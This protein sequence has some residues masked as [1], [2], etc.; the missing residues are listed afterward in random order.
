ML[1]AL[2]VGGVADI[3]YHLGA[4]CL[5][6]RRLERLDEVMRQTAD[7]SD[8]VDEHDPPAV[9]QHQRA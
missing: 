8:G 5:L 7:K 2:G 3:Q 4:D 6:K 9:G 1:G